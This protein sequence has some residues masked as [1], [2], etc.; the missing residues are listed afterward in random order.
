MS[1]AE[2]FAGDLV[3]LD[4]GWNDLPSGNYIVQEVKAGRDFPAS[5]GIQDRHMD[6]MYPVLLDQSGRARPVHTSHL[7][8]VTRKDIPLSDNGAAEYEEIMQAQESLDL[9]KMQG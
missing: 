6:F 5:E 2:F 1:T 4:G 9:V 3:Y 7:T 8:L